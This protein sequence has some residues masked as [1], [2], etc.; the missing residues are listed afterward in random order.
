MTIGK[1]LCPDWSAVKAMRCCTESELS[2]ER[3]L[4][5]GQLVE[6]VIEEAGPRVR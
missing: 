5:G 3:I 6:R 2:D 1:I 4:G